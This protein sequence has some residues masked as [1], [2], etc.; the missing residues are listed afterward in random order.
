M[1]IILLTLVFFF[2]SPLLSANV[3]YSGQE[4]RPIKSLSES[5]MLALKNGSGWGLAKSAELNG[6]PGPVHVIELQEELD[7]SESQL[8]QVQAIWQNMNSE[9]IKQGERYIQ[10]EKA[11]ERYFQERR[12]NAQELKALL[13]HSA[14]QLALLR[15]VHLDAHLK[16]KPILSQHQVMLYKRHRGYDH[17]SAHHTNHH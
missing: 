13:A 3:S 11:I 12:D 10:A 15:G 5:D 1:K 4:N 6:L 17:S 14:Q 2:F 7:L 9:A 8:K 16:I